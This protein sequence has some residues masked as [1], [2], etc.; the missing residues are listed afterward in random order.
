MIE[1]PSENISKLDLSNKN[2][3]EIPK[4]VLRLKNLRKLNLSGNNLK[5]IPKDIVQLKNLENL[6]VSKN[7]ISNLFAKNFELSKLKT[8]IL[9]ENNIKTIPVQIHNLSSLRKLQ[10][11]DNRI[12]KLPPSFSSLK[13]LKE[14]NI[15]NNPIEIFPKEITSLNKLE[16]LWINNL[17]LKGLPRKDLLKMPQL[18]YLYCYSP[19]IF[20]RNLSSEYF[21]LSKNKGNSYS[22]LEGEPETFNQSQTELKFEESSVKNKIF[23]SYSHADIE[24]FKA[25]KTHLKALS[26]VENDFEVWDDSKIKPSERWRDE[27]AAALNRSEIAILLISTNFLAS[28]FIRTDELPILLKKA[29][30]NG[31]KLLSLIVGTSLY[32]LENELPEYQAINSPDRPLYKLSKPEQDEELVKLAKTV[33]DIIRAN[34]KG[35]KL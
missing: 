23:I 8:L 32:E 5:Q 14:L 19:K 9:N 24:W 31:T 20:S 2:L 10:L 34:S 21:L 1:I 3:G 15:S 26:F 17:K 30:T 33:R 12:E 35:R 16:R 29:K 13:N 4:E 18:R 6:D 22:N 25:V 11:A 27:I 28:D 7:K